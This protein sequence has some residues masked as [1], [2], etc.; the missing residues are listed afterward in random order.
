MP[1][2][3][4]DLVVVGASAGGVKALRTV[5]QKGRFPL[6]TPDRA[7]EGTTPA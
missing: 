6:G 4:R 3:R 2:F 1:P 7:G 5:L